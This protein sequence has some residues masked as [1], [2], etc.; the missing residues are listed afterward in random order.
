M[1]NN[2]IIVEPK[3]S[4]VTHIVNVIESAKG[5][6]NCA[7][8]TNTNK[9]YRS[10]W[11]D[12]SAWCKTNGM[13]ALPAEPSTVALYLTDRASNLKTASLARRLTS[14]REAHRLAGR[15]LN[16]QHPAIRET[17]K[18]IRNTLGAAQRGKIPILIADLRDMVAQLPDTLIGMRDRALL[19][20]GF[21]G[22]FRRSELVGIDIQNLSFGRDGLTIRIGKSKTDQEGKGREVGIPYGSN[23]KI[24]PIRA[25]EDWINASGIKEGALYCSVNRHGQV[26][27]NGLSDKAVAL[28]VKRAAYASAFANGLDGNLAAREASQF[29]GHSY[30]LA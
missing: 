11:A 22:A 17:W 13:C 29:A 14:I 20:I 24:C 1:P 10:D 3:T 12:F 15:P 2:L 19:L 25:A 18:G 9:A 21:S 30:A 5:Y 27:S 16:T 26:Q 4:E 28:I 23:P 7:R 6:A 8:S